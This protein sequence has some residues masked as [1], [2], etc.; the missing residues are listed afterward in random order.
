MLFRSIT[1][2]TRID[3]KTGTVQTGTLWNEEYL[4]TETIMYSLMMS[5]P[6]LIKNKKE[7]SELSKIVNDDPQKESENVLKVVI[8]QLDK[9]EQVLPR[10]LFLGGNETIGK[11]LVSLK[12]IWQGG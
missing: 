11:G 6:L 8:G 5:T 10:Y 4:P 3:L 7:R 2:R 12:V 1:T 9:G